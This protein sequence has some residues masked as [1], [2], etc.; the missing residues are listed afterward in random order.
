MVLGSSVFLSFFGY[1]SLFCKGI[2]TNPLG[3]YV[4]LIGPFNQFA[5]LNFVFLTSWIDSKESCTDLVNI[6]LSLLLVRSCR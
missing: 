4:A 6:L 3:I 5:L 2:H 1:S